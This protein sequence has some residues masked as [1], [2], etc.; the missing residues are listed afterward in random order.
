MYQLIVKHRALIMVQEAYNWYEK[1][2]E[3]LGEQFLSELDI[4][5]EKLER[6]PEFYGKIE[7]NYRQVRLKR[8]PYLV[9]YEIIEKKVVVF[10]VFHTSRNPNDKFKG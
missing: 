9:V 3:G 5:Y 1:Q 8:F 10:A 7:N 2:K 6:T 4:Y